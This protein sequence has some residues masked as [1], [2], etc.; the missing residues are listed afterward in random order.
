MASYC[1]STLLEDFGDA[2]W[3]ADALAHTAADKGLTLPS[4]YAALD[5]QLPGGGWP[6]GGLCELLQAHTGQAEWGLL[7]PALRTL[8]Q[9]V[10]LVGTPWV[11]FGPGLAAQGL[12]VQ[13]LLW[14]QA[15][16]MVQRLW[17]AEQ[18]LR[19]TGVDALLL[20]LPEVRADHL[21]R[22]Q[23]AAQTHAKLLWVMRP[24]SARHEASPAALRLLLNTPGDA[25]T[26]PV[27]ILKRRGPPLAQT[28]LLPV[29]PAVLCELL[30]W[31]AA[32][33]A[34][35]GTTPC[36]R[37]EPFQSAQTRVL[38]D[39]PGG[40]GSLKTGLKLASQRDLPP[41][42]QTHALDRLA[43]AA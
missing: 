18:V 35:P 10:A 34:S 21:R 37:P 41:P 1:V 6:V 19:C 27:Q 36:R 42:E 23:L 3:R 40:S 32:Q 29:H 38:A 30:A 26:L 7:L 8:G 2:V 39:F 5:A 20:W 12:D 13:A 9:T 43:N 28:L 4:G 24:A 33:A 17:A 15:E 16:A 31:G 11:P 22:L 25:L 14:V